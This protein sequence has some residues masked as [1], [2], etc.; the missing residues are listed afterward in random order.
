M[1]TENEEPEL[2]VSRLGFDYCH[3]SIIIRSQGVHRT[4]E[5]ESTAALG[6]VQLSKVLHQPDVVVPSGGYNRKVTA[7]GR[8]QTIRFMSAPSDPTEGG[9]R[10]RKSTYSSTMPA[11]L[12]VDR[13]PALAVRSPIYACRK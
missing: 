2:Q 9:A 11:W 10:L 5:T 13:K 8:W 12:L 4:V 6:M 7:V 1:L 3:F